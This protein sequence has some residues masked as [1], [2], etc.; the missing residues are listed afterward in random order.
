MGKTESGS[1][2]VGV[3]TSLLMLHKAVKSAFTWTDGGKADAGSIGIS[4]V[5]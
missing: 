1:V 4:R 5:Q 2:G 3:K